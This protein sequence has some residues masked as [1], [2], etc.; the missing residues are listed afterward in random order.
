MI[1]F[2]SEDVPLPPIVEEN[3]GAWI[4]ACVQAF[5]QTEVE[6][7]SV[8]FCSDEYLLEMN[9]THLNHDYYTDIIT[10]EY[11]SKPVAGDLFISTDR[12]AD[13]ATKL[14]V[15]I[16]EELHRVI[17][18]GVLHLIGYKDKTEPE[19]KEMREMENRALE[20]YVSRGT[21]S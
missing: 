18:H 10:F 19:S 6:E 2:Y 9:R 20:M 4:K 11:S 13:N 14:E 12:V 7:V 17:I 15:D 21:N 1:N 3:V 16:K 8:V 5:A